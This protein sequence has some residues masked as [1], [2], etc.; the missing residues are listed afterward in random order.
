MRTDWNSIVAPVAFAFEKASLFK[1][2]LE[3]L[4]T[5]TIVGTIGLSSDDALSKYD[6]MY[7]NGCR[8]AVNVSS[9]NI[10]VGAMVVGER[11][12]KNAAG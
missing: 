2:P 5:S 9:Q 4:L 6:A 11:G 3:G 10:F 1:E 7:K 12:H 8:Q